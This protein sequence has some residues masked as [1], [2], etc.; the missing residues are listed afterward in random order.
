M[1]TPEQLACKDIDDLLRQCGWIVQDRT[2]INLGVGRGGV[3]REFPLK[4]GY[5]D[6]LLSFFAPP[7]SCSCVDGVM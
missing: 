1:P 5:A 6:Y 7:P 4:T 3:T 2:E